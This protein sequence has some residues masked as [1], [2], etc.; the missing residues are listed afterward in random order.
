MSGENQNQQ[1]DATD[2]TPAKHPE[3]SASRNERADAEAGYGPLPVRGVSYSPSRRDRLRPAELVGFSAVIALF[4]GLITLMS[5]RQWDFAGIAFG[6]VFII[7]LVV[8]AMFS[9][10]FKPNAEES[11]DL[12]EQNRGTQA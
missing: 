7:T 4:V 3:P 2:G 11:Q 12:D 9:L 6:V 8:L 5:I 10:S 1:P